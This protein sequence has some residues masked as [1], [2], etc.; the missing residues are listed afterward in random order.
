MT[1]SV[2]YTIVKNIVKGPGGKHQV[3]THYG[4]FSIPESVTGLAMLKPGV[5]AMF[6]LKIKEY[7]RTSSIPPTWSVSSIQTNLSGKEMYKSLTLK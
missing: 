3:K 5:S 2:V 7:G 1:D 6:H 4:D